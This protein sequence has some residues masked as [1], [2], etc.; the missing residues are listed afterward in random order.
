LLFSLLLNNLEPVSQTAQDLFLCS[1]EV[2][3]EFSHGASAKLPRAAP[4]RS[5]AI[6]FHFSGHN[7]KLCEIV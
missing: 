2:L 3:K 5:E 4:E 7:Y 1:T 6:L